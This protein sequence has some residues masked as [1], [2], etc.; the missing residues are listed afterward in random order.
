MYCEEHTGWD[1]A[2]TPG[3]QPTAF[4]LLWPLQGGSLHHPVTPFCC[5]EES[6]VQK[7]RV[8][9][10]HQELSSQPS[11]TNKD[12]CTDAE[13]ILG[14]SQQLWEN[15]PKCRTSSSAGLLTVQDFLQC[16]TSYSACTHYSTQSAFHCIV[17]WMDRKGASQLGLASLLRITKVDA[18][19]WPSFFISL[20]SH[21][22]VDAMCCSKHWCCLLK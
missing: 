2:F 13:S 14:H 20:S 5:S 17:S 8:S 7:P 3:I 1:G 15:M 19:M 11:C 22:G 18:T 9:N 16:R 12:V 21:R 10:N 4:Q 6:T